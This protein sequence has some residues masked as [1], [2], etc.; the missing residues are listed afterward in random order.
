[1]LES[2][3][4][5]ACDPRKTPRFHVVLPVPVQSPATGRSPGLPYRYWIVAFDG[6][7]AMKVGPGKSVLCVDAGKA[8]LDPCQWSPGTTAID[9]SRSTRLDLPLRKGVLVVVRLHDPTGAAQAVRT[10]TS[11]LD[12][13]PA[14][15]VS[16][17]IEDAS[18]AMRPVPFVGSTATSA[19]FSVLVP[20]YTGF[21]LV[22]G[23]SQLALADTSSSPLA[24]NVFRT[25]LTSPTAST[26]APILSPLGRPWGQNIPSQVFNILITGL[27]SH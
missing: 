2:A 25:S 18:G 16:V 13:V 24:Q 7:F 21:N 12:S 14:P 22:V 11:A 9:T 3:I 5:M 15:P 1:V 20:S 4:Q 26:S 23:S 8:Y 10:A 27:V 6:T 19:D 17:M